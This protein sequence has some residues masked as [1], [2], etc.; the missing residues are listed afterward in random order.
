VGTV[1]QLGPLLAEPIVYGTLGASD[2]TLAPSGPAANAAIN[3]PL[4]SWSIDAAV[5]AA[6]AN[7]VTLGSRLQLRLRTTYDNHLNGAA[8]AF[9]FDSGETTTLA[10]RPMLIV[11]YR[12]P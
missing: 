10:R 3:A 2:F 1:S 5:T 9:D 8:D 6:W 7:R 4:V 11:T 12:A